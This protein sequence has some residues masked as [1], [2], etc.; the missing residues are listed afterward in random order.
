MGNG[1]RP[2][3]SCLTLSGGPQSTIQHGEDT[4]P[5]RDGPDRGLRLRWCSGPG[6]PPGRAPSRPRART[7]RTGGG[8]LRGRGTRSRRPPSPARPWTPRRPPPPPWAWREGPASEFGGD[9]RAPG[10]DP[11]ARQHRPLRAGTPLGGPPADTAGSGVR[12]CSPSPRAPTG[13]RSLRAELPRPASPSP[14]RALLI[15]EKGQRTGAPA[16]MG[17]RGRSS[18]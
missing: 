6:R 17:E 3:G 4:L 11:R 18:L 9:R 1:T 13:G 12:G 15:P 8:G 5:A 7:A 14:G 10:H 16:A 2:P